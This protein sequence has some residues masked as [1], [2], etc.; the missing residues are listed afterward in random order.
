MRTLN[1]EKYNSILEEARK[2]FTLNGFKESSMRTI[3]QNS[4]VGLSNIYNYFIN[5]DDIFL[6]VVNPAKNRL[7]SFVS[8]RHTEAKMM[9]DHSNSQEYSNEDIETY[10]DLLFQYKDELRLL[11]FQSQGSS[12]ENFR[13][14]ITDHMTT[15]S[16]EYMVMGKKHFPMTKEISPFFI[17]TMSSWMVSIIGE[18]ITHDLDKNTIRDFF[19]EYFKFGYAGW[20]ELIEI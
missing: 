4:G 18:L 14:M 10:I 9:I 19:H 7:M 3:S 17:H 13:D 16:H 5:K 8:E 11:L 12:L 2:E 15:V 1:D 20:R 6:A